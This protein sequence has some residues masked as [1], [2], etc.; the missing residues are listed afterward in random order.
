MY[1]NKLGQIRGHR[2][3]VGGRS[4][5]S[6]QMVF[7]Y[8][9]TPAW[10]SSVSVEGAYHSSLH[11][12]GLGFYSTMRKWVTRRPN[13]YRARPLHVSDEW[14]RGLHIYLAAAAERERELPTEHVSLIRAPLQLIEADTRGR[15][16]RVCS[17]EPWGEI[18]RTERYCWLKQL[19]GYKWTTRI[20]PRSS[21]S[22]FWDDLIKRRYAYRKHR[23]KSNINMY[24]G[25][26]ASQRSS[27]LGLWE[28]FQ[29]L[30]ISKI[31]DFQPT[32]TTLRTERKQ[33][34]VGLELH[35]GRSLLGCKVHDS[36][37]LHLMILKTISVTMLY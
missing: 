14:R 5:S 2:E 28:C 3:H 12:W 36:T 18:M 25:H 32:S 9:L 11:I 22:D 37:P 1:Q 24:P 6:P 26:R 30:Y 27:R 33:V 17:S 20:I 19:N 7:I 34:L 29:S 15:T 8:S 23:A 35:W 4:P 10:T 21:R 16:P 13:A 31:T